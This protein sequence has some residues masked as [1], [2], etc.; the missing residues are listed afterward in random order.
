MRLDTGSDSDRLSPAIRV[1]GGIVATT[2]S[3]QNEEDSCYVT[4]IHTCSVGDVISWTVFHNVG[5]TVNT[6]AESHSG[7]MGF[8]LIGA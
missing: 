1:N 4:K 6:K 7:F 5:S 8:R 3:R 2:N